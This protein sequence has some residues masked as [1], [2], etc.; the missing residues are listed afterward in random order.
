MSATREALERRLRALVPGRLLR[1]R[2]ATR[3]LA[4]WGAGRPVRFL[5]AGCEVGLLSLALARRRPQWTFEAVDIDEEMLA[6]G[7]EWAAKVRAPISFS[8]ADLTA[9][10][11]EGRYDAIAALECLAEIPDAAAALRAM[12]GALR[13]GGLLAVHVPLADWQPVLPG[14]PRT[15]EREVRHGY[16]P[17]ELEAE[18]AALGL[19]VTYRRDTMRAAVQASHEL[20]DRVKRRPL[21]VRAVVLPLL[22]VPVELE[23][24]GV[25]FGAPRGLYVE[26]RRA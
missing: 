26:A 18:L 4:A 22:S 13:P 5:D 9:G 19:E 25:A 7:R 6:Q 16:A 23:L 15:W 14:S 17:G 11:P 2:L 21:R 8:A 12:A 24:R 10:L 1:T 20:R 3:R